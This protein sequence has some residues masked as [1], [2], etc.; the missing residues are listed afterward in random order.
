MSDVKYKTDLEKNIAYLFN[1]YKNMLDF[2]ADEG[3]MDLME[4]EQIFNLL[5]NLNSIDVTIIEPI[6]KAYQ[7]FLDGDLLMVKDFINLLYLHYHLTIQ[8]TVVAN[9]LDS[10]FT[11]DGYPI[12]DKEE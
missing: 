1:K 12:N 11:E 2:E 9:Y 7:A 6:E 10:N 8:I 5:T 4:F 3:A